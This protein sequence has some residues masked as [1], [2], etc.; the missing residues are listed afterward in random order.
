MIYRIA[1]DVKPTS[2]SR[3]TAQADE[4]IWWQVTQYKGMD[5]TQDTASY[6]SSLLGVAKS[7]KKSHD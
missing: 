2:V 4:V 3:V 7:I 5:I 6:V 1:G